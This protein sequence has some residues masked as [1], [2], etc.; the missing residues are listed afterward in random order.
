MSGSPSSDP[1]GLPLSTSD[2]SPASASDRAPVLELDRAAVRIG[3]RTIWSDVSLRVDA[4]EFVALLGA[5]GSG[6]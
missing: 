3:R 4:G 1:D 5:N 6:K 2:G